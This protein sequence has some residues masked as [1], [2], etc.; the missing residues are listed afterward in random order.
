MK[1]IIVP[2]PKSDSLIHQLEAFYN[3]FKNINHAEAVNFDLSKINWVYPLTILPISSH[4]YATKSKYGSP[5]NS[6]VSQYLKTIYFPNGVSH[7]ASFQ[8]AKNYIPISLIQKRNN[9][10]EREK[11]LYCFLNLIYKTIGD[12]PGTK[13]AIFYPILELVNNIFEHSRKDYGFIFGQ[14]YHQKKYLDLCILDRGRGLTQS[15][16]QEKDIK[17]SHREAIAR[18]M[19]GDSTKGKERGYGLKTSKKTVCEGFKGE[20]LI[21]SGDACLFSKGKQDQQESRDTAWHR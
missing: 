2:K 1:N 17:I 16:E 19:S 10:N 15:Y 21:L 20:F 7:I 14:I 3:T 18:A 6:E 11:V 13:D 9:L 5:L 8:D 4:I 12:I